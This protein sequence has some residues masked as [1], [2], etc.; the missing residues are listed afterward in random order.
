M[1]RVLLTKAECAALRGLAILGIVLHNYTHWLG[2]AVKENEYQFHRN[3][4]D[5]LLHAVL[6]ADINL[7]IHLL[8]F[9]GHYGVPV[10]LFLS[11]YGLVL[12]YEK[13][14]NGNPNL[15]GNPNVNGNSKQVMRNVAGSLSFIRYH[16][17]KLFRMM[18]VGFVAFVMLDAITPGRHHYQLLHVVAQL[19]MFNNLLPTPDKV[20]WPGPYWFFGLMLQLY[21]VYRLLIWRRHWGI[22]VGLMV[23]CWLLQAFCEPEGELLNRLRYNFV[24]GMLP[25]GLGVLLARFQSRFS[26][27][28][29]T[30]KGRYAM[31]LLTASALV[32]LLSFNQQTWYWVPVFVVL[33]S[34]ALV[35]VLPRKMGSMLEWTGGVSAAM[36]VCHP[37]ARKIII[38]PYRTHDIY[39]GLLL[40]LV[41][42]ICLAWLF[43][44][45]MKHIPEPKNHS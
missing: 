3:N 41:A 38:A 44:E 37:I 15:T 40:Y 2:M 31:L 24:G 4:C 39:A 16:F 36:F 18:I 42:S 20:I 13:N 34:V 22:V 19:G 6:H 8:S 26:A 43:A 14:L 10:F 12:K 35:K 30:G 9:F 29:S 25:F 33:A 28:L 5:G 27:S 17:L 32:F 21:I 7:P 23:V 45:V 1:N 11:G